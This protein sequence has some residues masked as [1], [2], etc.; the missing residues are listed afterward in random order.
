MDWTGRGAMLPRI[1][2]RAEDDRG[3]TYYCRQ[4][5]GSG[6]GTPPDHPSWR[7]SCPFL[8]QLDPEAQRLTLEIEMMQWGPGMAALAA[9]DPLRFVVELA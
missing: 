6:G 8:P 1:T 7:V 2:W 5:A 9:E 4:C 3:G